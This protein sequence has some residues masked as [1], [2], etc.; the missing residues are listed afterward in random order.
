LTS[1]DYVTRNAFNIAAARPDDYVLATGITTE[2]RE[3]IALAFDEVG[4][5]VKFQGKG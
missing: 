2:I 1:Q 4:L 3:F 5:N